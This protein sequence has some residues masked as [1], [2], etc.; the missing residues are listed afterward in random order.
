MVLLILWIALIVA[1]VTLLILKLIGTVKGVSTKGLNN[2][3]FVL[4]CI[5]LLPITVLVALVKITAK[6][7]G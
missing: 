7:W 5:A 4:S 1:I 3:I 2:A 6:R